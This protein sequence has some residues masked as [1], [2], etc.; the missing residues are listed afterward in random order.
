[1]LMLERSSVPS[2]KAR[3]TNA[4]D[5]DRRENCQ[6]RRMG[7][8]MAKCLRCAKHEIGVLNAQCSAG[9]NVLFSG[10][11]VYRLGLQ[12]RSHEFCCVPGFAVIPVSRI[13]GFVDCN[14]DRVVP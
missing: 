14:R 2:R 10:W 3:Y 13:G 1:M 8:T 9:T 5:P 6:M 7:E 11:R 12:Y 4:A